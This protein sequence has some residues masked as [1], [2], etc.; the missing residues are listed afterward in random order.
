MNPLLN[1][2]PVLRSRLGRDEGGATTLEWSVLASSIA[3]V[4]VLSIT[5][6][7]QTVAGLFGQAAN[8]I[9]ALL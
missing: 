2:F 8:V 1:K 4:A 9:G 6:L 3:A 7:G 5:N